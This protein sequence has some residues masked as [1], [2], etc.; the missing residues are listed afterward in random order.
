MGV[1]LQTFYWDCPRED[2]KEFQWWNYIRYVLNNRGDMWQG[3]WVTTQWT[4][5]SFRPTA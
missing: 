2:N 3:Q 5:A 1:M 4:N